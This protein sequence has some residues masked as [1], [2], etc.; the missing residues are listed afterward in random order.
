MNILW[1]NIVKTSRGENIMK[2][3]KQKR[4]PAIVTKTR[5]DNSIEVEIRK[6]PQ[7]TLSGKILIIVILAAMVVLPVVGLIIVLVSQ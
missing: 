2:K 6:S 1:Y 5:I 3:N 4:D 7:K